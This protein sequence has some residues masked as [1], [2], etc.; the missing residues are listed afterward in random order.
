MM[1]RLRSSLV[2]RGGGGGPGLMGVAGQLCVE[3]GLEEALVAVG[4]HQAVD[5]VL[6][7]LEGG[8]ARAAAQS[9]T[10]ELPDRRVNVD[11]RRGGG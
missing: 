8:G 1:R 6:G 4:L 7:Q 5:L 11:L 10:R 3:A 2:G 9:L